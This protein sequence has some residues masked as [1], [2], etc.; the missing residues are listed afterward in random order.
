M[1]TATSDADK[2]RKTKFQ[3]ELGGHIKLLRKKKGL[4]GAEFGRRLEMER[5]HVARLESGG[6]NPSAFLIFKIC[7]VLK[8][9]LSDFWV[10]FKKISSE[11]S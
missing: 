7:A 1:T 3:K 2:R 8:I 10:D 11:Q 6:T 5:S 9:S 4:S